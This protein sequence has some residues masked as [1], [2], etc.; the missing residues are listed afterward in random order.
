MEASAQMRQLEAHRGKKAL[1]CD[2]SITKSWQTVA[3]RIQLSGG[4]GDRDVEEGIIRAGGAGS[5]QKHQSLGGLRRTTV[6]S[7]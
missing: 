7:N 4:R 5:C 2:V 1:S 6:S 3:V